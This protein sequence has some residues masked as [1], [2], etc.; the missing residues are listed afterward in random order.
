MRHLPL[1]ALATLALSACDDSAIPGS[2]ADMGPD[3]IEGS[4]LSLSEGDL[5]ARVGA[6][7]TSLR[8]RL[9]KEGSQSI[10]GEVRFILLRIGDGEAVATATASFEASETL[11]EVEADLEFG[12]PEAGEDPA[13]LGAWVVNYE[14]AWPG[15][16]GLRG[17]RSLF[18]AQEQIELQLLSTDTFQVGGATHLQVFARDPGSGAPLKGASVTVGL[19]RDGEA[20]EALVDETDAHGHV[21]VELPTAEGTETGEAELVV[22]VKA[23]DGVAQARADVAVERATKVLLTT[24]KPLYQPGQTMHLRALALRRPSLAADGGQPM[25][26][27]VFDG[28]DN[29]VERVETETDGFGV[30][31]TRFTLARE[32]NMGRYRIAATVA[33]QTTEKAV[34]VERYALPKYDLDLTLERE[35]YLA[36]DTLRGILAA[37]Y[38]FGQA[39]AGAHVAVEAATLDAGRTVFAELQGMTNEDGLYA[40]EAQLPDYVVGLPLEQGGG[41]VEL[42]VSVEDSAGQRRDVTRTLRVARGALEVVVVPESGQLV[43]GL[44]N[45]LLVRCTDAAGQPAAATHVVEVDGAALPAFE[46][47]ADGMGEVSVEVDDAALD[48]VVVS[49]DDT[50]HEVITEIRLVATPGGGT[51]GVLVRTDRALYRV[52]DTLQVEVRTVGAPDRVFVDVV[53]AGRTLLTEAM[54]PD[55]DGIASYALDLSPDHAGALQVTAYTLSA[56][57]SLRRDA[58]LVYVEPA[59]AL[60][61][62][63]SADREVYAPAEEARL[64]FRVTDEVGEARPTAIGVQVVDEAVFGLVE[65]RPGLE[66]AYFRIEGELAEPRYQVGVPGLATITG[67]A[68]APEDPTAQA[69]ARMLLSAT[70]ARD[71]HPVAIN[72]FELSQRGVVA[73]VRPAIEAL[74]EAWF[75]TLAAQDAGRDDL[76]ALRERVE[77]AGDLP[78]DPFGE[79]LEAAI[80]D[81]MVVVRS[82]G[83]DE[84]AGSIDDVEVRRSVW[85]VLR[86][87]DDFDDRVNAGEGEG[88]PPPQAED[89][90]D[91]QGIRVR[92]DFPE[93]LLVE[94]ALLTDADGVASLALPLADSITTWRVSALANTAGGL[95]GS[96]T[97]GVRV[98]QD[99]FVDIDFPA[100]LTRGDEF[101]VPVAVYNYLDVPQRVRLEVQPADW[102]TLLGEAAMVL[103][104]GPG[105]VSGVRV[106][107]RVDRV[108]LHELLVVA[109]GDALQDAVARTVL[110]EPDGQAVRQT[111]SGRLEGVVR[112]EVALPVDAVEGSGKLLVKVYPGLFASIV[113]G[114]DA[115]LRMPS[116]CFEQTSS[117]TWPN[118]LVLRYMRDTQAG[119]PEVEITATQY[120][121][122]GYQRLLTFEVDGGG[123]E[124][125]G[126]APAHIVLTAYGLLEFADLAAV[127]MVDADMV[128]RTRAW[129]LAQ[130]EDDGHWEVA[131]RG[132]DETGQLSDPVTVTA[133]V[134]FGLAAAGEEAPALG[135]ARDWLAG[136]FDEMGTYTLALFTNFLVAFEPDGALTRRAL[137]RLAE[138]VDEATGDVPGHWET[139][140]QTTTY[141]AGEAAYIETTALATHALLA[142]GS[143]GAVAEEAL[144]WL[145]SRKD[146]NGGWGSTAGTVWTI[147]CLLQALSGA[148]DDTADA[149]VRVRL[150]GEEHASFRITADDSDVMRQADLSEAFAQGP[151]QLVEVEIQGDGR[152]QYAIV[153]GHHRPWSD[154]PPPEG[155]LSIEVS[156]DRTSLEVDDMLAV[157]VRVENRDIAYA[158][159]VLVDLGIPPG[160]DLVTADLDALAETGV[161]SRYERTERQL[162]IYFT[163]IRPEAPVEFSYRLRARDPIRAQAPRSRVYSY[164][165]QD[166]GAETEPV[167]IE[168]R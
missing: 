34:S 32:V 112:R 135:R 124:W 82:H 111:W 18:A 157:T 97:A 128:E 145:V 29:K 149:T 103:D 74:A 122:T 8:L 64:E 37:R 102:L 12:V 83:P 65:F 9:H 5:R 168:V 93:T 49:T 21:A 159:M 95:L 106:P 94:P 58:A 121:N 24:D 35:V 136:H 114:L 144:D 130:Q 127:R 75:A 107:V 140:E 98:F 131:S 89:G 45:R 50:G 6:D 163:V 105:E 13:V 84:Q 88:E 152:L 160:F 125:F 11:T 137:D 17:V 100:T 91:P 14:V 4:T 147:K 69:E 33:G 60:H 142:S 1:V 133:Y 22:A 150:D 19:E 96:A 48:L 3:Q 153:A 27:E 51:G 67:V 134:A 158:D 10:E 20:I 85:A 109:R 73:V 129:V 28:K 72:T 46:T 26:F 57:S 117:S 70:D 41:M 116:G 162:L 16:E 90:G 55:E 123:F 56:G 68:G 66:R 79:R 25:I 30:A 47:G 156:Y 138:A 78:Q 92:R 166:V 164:Y 2:S 146:Q 87:E 113:E 120:V 154:A 110:V 148:A 7:E 61:V 139:D 42:A 151:P 44:E 59:D 62:E 132:L 101:S 71:A 119:T 155:P 104:L 161:F 99:F 39:V 86:G 53:G 54:S 43:V 143:H 115:L 36:G 81:D 126:N 52:G 80:E 63:V 40:F 31:A 167:E 15:G 38:F 141:G 165:N 108:G 76:E 118:A 23:G 77:T